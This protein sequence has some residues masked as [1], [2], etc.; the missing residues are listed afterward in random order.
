MLQFKHV[1][2]EHLTASIII[3]GDIVVFGPVMKFKI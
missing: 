1:V 3:K 2:K